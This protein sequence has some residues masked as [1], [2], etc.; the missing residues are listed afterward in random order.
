[1]PPVDGRFPGRYQ[2]LVSGSYLLAE[3]DADQPDDAGH[4]AVLWFCP[5]WLG[6]AQCLMAGQ[7]LMAGPAGDTE[8]GWELGVGE[9]H[10][11][12]VTW[13]PGPDAPSRGIPGPVLETGH[14]YFVAAS[15]DSAG[16]VTLVVLPRGTGGGAV[17]GG[18][19]AGI[20]A[21][22]G[23]RDLGA[24]CPAAR[25]VS[26]GAAVRGGS[27]H[28]CFNGKIDTPRLFARPAAGGQP[29]CARGRR[30]GRA[31]RPAAPRVALQPGR[32]AAAAPGPRQRPGPV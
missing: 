18:I 31:R 11:V 13:S 4:T 15:W 26:V 12:S 7:G 14:W 8:G 17:P 1:M 20:P 19:P 3:L 28:R 16:S 21:D 25:V 30:G 29:D 24:P 32:G 5:T 9:D 23:P 22:A 6:R 10:R 2:E 27:V